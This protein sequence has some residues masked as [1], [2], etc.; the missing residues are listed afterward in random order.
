MFSE[1]IKQRLEELK[2][3]KVIKFTMDLGIEKYVH[4]KEL[5]VY[6]EIEFMESLFDNFASPF[7]DIV[8]I[9]PVE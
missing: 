1:E 6:Y 4:L 2:D 3:C 5:K 9:V 8:S 7:P